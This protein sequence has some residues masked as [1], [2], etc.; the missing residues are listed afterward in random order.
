MK[1]KSDWQKLIR[2]IVF[3]TREGKEKKLHARVQMWDFPHHIFDLE[4]ITK[5][6]EKVIKGKSFD[7]RRSHP[8]R[9]LGFLDRNYEITNVGKNFLKAG[10]KKFI[11]E[12]QC[13]KW[14]Y[15]NRT[16][17]RISSAAQKFNI[18]PFWVCLSFM[19]LLKKR[20]N[21]DILFK[22]EAIFTILSIKKYNEI[23]ERLEFLA[24]FRERSAEDQ[25]QIL[26]Q[27]HLKE[28]LDFL[29]KGVCYKLFSAWTRYFI[30]DPEGNLI[31]NNDTLKE[32]SQIVGLFNKLYSNKKIPLWDSNKY[33]KLL[34]SEKSFES[35]FEDKEYVNIE[36]AFPD[37]SKIHIDF[38]DLKIDRAGLRKIRRRTKAYPKIV[39]FERETARRKRIGDLGEEIVLKKERE[40]LEQNGKINLSKQVKQISKVDTSAGYD[41]LSYE[42]SGEKK[43]IEV[44]ST[45][46]PPRRTFTFIITIN[47][48]ERAKKM[49]NYYLYIVF[50]TTSKN[51]K[52]WGLKNPFIGKGKGIFITPISFR[53]MV[54]IQGI[55]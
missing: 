23:P 45:S 3:T 54:S 40:F 22:E 37:I 12:N 55:I 48:Y 6:L 42:L 15:P 30:L 52:I 16:L 53:V 8:L 25:D 26:S 14:H 29:Y 10:I 43:Y 5:T 34:Y 32:A 44:K 50:N 19:L 21:S 38:I 39:D 28:S 24:D 13:K 9:S 20:L 51:P 18:F 27:M 36:S 7:K 49:K 1:S 11:I 2:N 47:E 35:Y 41:V 46:T 17:T 31:L 33:E 4:T